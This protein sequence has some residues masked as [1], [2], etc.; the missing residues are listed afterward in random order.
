MKI[1]YS[2]QLPYLELGIRPTARLLAYGIH[3][4]CTIQNHLQLW[5]GPFFSCVFAPIRAFLDHKS[6][7]A[8]FRGSTS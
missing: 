5:Q 2:K 7:I 8:Q 1:A 3:L 6:L 4:W